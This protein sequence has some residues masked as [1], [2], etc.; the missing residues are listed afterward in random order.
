MI[1]PSALLNVDILFDAK[2]DAI[3]Y[4]YRISYKVSQL[5]LAM[6]I[7]GWGS[8]CTCS[9]IKLHMISFALISPDYMRRLIAFAEGECVTPIVRFDPAVNKALTYANAYGFIIQQ[10]NGKF[11]LSESGKKLSDH[12]L[13]AGDLLTTEVNDLNTLAK[14]LTE[15]KVQMLV[16]IWRDTNVTD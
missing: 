6:K 7:C 8:D 9:L 4:N 11:A 14:R 3:P 10:R 1:E 13:I 2:P 16:D 5:C 12:I 15:A